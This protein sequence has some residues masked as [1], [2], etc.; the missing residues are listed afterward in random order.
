M[1]H[2]QRKMYLQSFWHHILLFPEFIQRVKHG[3]TFPTEEALV[4]LLALIEA[5]RSG[6]LPT[7]SSEKY[8]KDMCLMWIVAGFSHQALWFWVGEW[9]PSWRYGQL[10]MLAVWWPSKVTKEVNERLE[11]SRKCC[12]WPK[13]I[14]NFSA[15]NCRAGSRCSS[16]LAQM[17]STAVLFSLDSCYW[18]RHR[19]KTFISWM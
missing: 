7:E 5:W 4:C 13:K 2:V 9:M 18:L 1:F 12:C 8:R 6:R 17:P 19:M 10:K 16:L 15:W 3:W 11:Q 14:R